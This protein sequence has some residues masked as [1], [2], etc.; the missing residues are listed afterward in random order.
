MNVLTVK[1]VAERLKVSQACVYALVA[2]G[3]LPAVRIGVGRG[4][5]RFNEEDFLE[6]LE[7]ARTHRSSSKMALNHIKRGALPARPP[8]ANDPTSSRGADSAS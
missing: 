1:E 3:R 7:A 5:I 8:S 4:V 6:F 2:Q